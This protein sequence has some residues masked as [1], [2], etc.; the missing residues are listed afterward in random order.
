MLVGTW[1]ITGN[2]FPYYEKYMQHLQNLQNSWGMPI[3]ILNKS[4][5]ISAVWSNTNGNAIQ[6]DAHYGNQIHDIHS[7]PPDIKGDTIGNAFRLLEIIENE[8]YA[9]SNTPSDFW[10]SNRAT[11]Y[12]EKYVRIHTLRRNANRWNSFGIR[13]NPLE[14]KMLGTIFASL[15]LSGP[16]KKNAWKH[17]LDL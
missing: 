12:H 3:E 15:Q 5:R 13:I 11:Q 16:Q 17:I 2:S 14:T 4:L 1:K 8:T 10:L 9:V 7:K 6:I